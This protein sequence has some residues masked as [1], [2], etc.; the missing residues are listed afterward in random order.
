MITTNPPPAF[1]HLPLLSRPCQHPKPSRP[2]PCATIQSNLGYHSHADLSSL[3]RGH[4][5][6]LIQRLSQGLGGDLGVFV[7]PASQHIG[8]KYEVRV[9]R[10]R[11]VELFSRA[12]REKVTGYNQHCP[13]ETTSRCTH[14][15][16]DL[17]EDDILAVNLGRQLFNVTL[18]PLRHTETRSLALALGGPCSAGTESKIPQGRSYSYN[19]EPA[20]TQASGWLMW[21]LC[22]VHGHHYKASYW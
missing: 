10:R 21:Q 17:H 4:S 20:H 14:D 5:V 13:L 6:R 7:P 3:L 11:F 2:A 18:Y 15:M 12:R 22:S 9:I 19:P 16:T 8:V 1:S